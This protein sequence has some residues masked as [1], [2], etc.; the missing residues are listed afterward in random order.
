MARRGVLGHATTGRR[1]SRRRIDAAHAARFSAIARRV[2]AGAG[3][4][5]KARMRRS[6]TAARL[7]TSRSAPRTCRSCA[8]SDARPGCG[9]AAQTCQRK[10]VSA[11]D[12]QPARRARPGASRSV[13]WCRRRAIASASVSSMSPVSR[14]ASI[15]MM[16]MP[17]RGIAGL[18]RALDRRGAAPAR[19]QRRVDVQAAQTRR[20][21]HPLRA[22]SGRT[23]RPPSHRGAR[24]HRVAGDAGVLRE[25]DRQGAGRAAATDPASRVRAQ[26]LAPAAV[27]ASS[28]D[29]A[30]GVRAP[31]GGSGQ[32]R[33]TRGGHLGSR[34]ASDGVRYT[35]GLTSRS[36]TSSRGAW[37]PRPRPPSAA[38]DCRSGEAR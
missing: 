30:A 18:D 36:G 16:V 10:R 21:Q 28:G 33:P 13:R 6:I 7:A 5:S 17:V 19:Q 38:A 4:G 2:G 22:G 24:A 8:R 9:A 1:R 35:Q 25:T 20:D 14:P 26:L 37:P 11:A 29:A 27:A 31:A 34:R 15:C 32:G 23:P 3:N 12:D